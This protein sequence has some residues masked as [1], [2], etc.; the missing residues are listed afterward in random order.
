MRP[1]ARLL[2]R[3][4][5]PMLVVRRLPE[6]AVAALSF[7]VWGALLLL[8]KTRDYIPPVP[9]YGRCDAVRAPVGQDGLAKSPMTPRDETR[10]SYFLA[11]RG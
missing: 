2:A 11:W 4:Q 8:G 3:L 9:R 10:L 1:T 6:M 7:S 5:S